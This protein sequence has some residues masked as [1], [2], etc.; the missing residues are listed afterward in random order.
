MDLQ[1]NRDL[2]F[3]ISSS[4]DCTAKVKNEEENE[5]ENKTKKMNMSFFFFFFFFFP[6]FSMLK[7]WNI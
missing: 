6:S 7:H 5:I 1:T 4:K 2:T 3:L